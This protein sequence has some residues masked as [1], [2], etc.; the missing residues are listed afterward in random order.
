M[1]PSPGALRAADAIWTQRFV[2][3]AELAEIIDREC[4]TAELVTALNDIV[5]MPEYDQDDQYRL[6]EKARAAL[7][8]HQ[9]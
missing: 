3:K 1:T 7:A 9:P 6:R 4:G 8:K 5:N 2:N